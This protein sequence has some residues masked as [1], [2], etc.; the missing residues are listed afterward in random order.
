MFKAI[1]A[2]EAQAILRRKGMCY[3]DDGTTFYAYDTESDEVYEYDS[4][5]DR[6]ASVRRVNA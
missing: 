6:D 4:R 5:K 2:R 1:T 3:G